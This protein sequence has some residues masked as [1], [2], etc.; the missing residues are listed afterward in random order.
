MK[1]GILGG[2]FDPIHHGHLAAARAAQDATG[3]DRVVFVPSHLPPHRGRAP[4]ASGFHRFAMTAIAVLADSSFEVSDI[5]LNRAGPSFSVDTI[6][7][8]HAGGWQAVQLFFIT[9][10]DAFADIRTWKAYPDLL[11]GCHFV[12][13]TRPGTRRIS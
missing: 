12:V 6:H 3:L 11:N 10:V 7:A 5:E 13:V 1:L 4:M 9:G 8:L 2:T